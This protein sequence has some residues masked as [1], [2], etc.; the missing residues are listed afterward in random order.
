MYTTIPLLCICI[1]AWYTLIHAS[2]IIMHVLA[3]LFCCYSVTVVRR[4]GTTSVL[5]MHRRM[6]KYY[7]FLCIMRSCV[8]VLCVLA[9]C[10]LVAH[11]RG[12]AAGF[13]SIAQGS[14]QT[15]ARASRCA[16]LSMYTYCFIHCAIFCAILLGLRWLCASV[17]TA[18]YNVYI[19]YD[20]QY[21]YIT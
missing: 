8:L 21:V 18:Q 19:C 13:A 1:R 11:R 4:R 14:T 12:R 20:I 16:V 3:T 6:L 10:M 15:A 17:T 5:Y 9:F 7:A 2:H